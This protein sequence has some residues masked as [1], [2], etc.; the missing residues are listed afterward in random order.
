VTISSRTEKAPVRERAANMLL[1]TRRVSPGAYRDALRSVARTL[2]QL[3]KMGVRAN[4]EVLDVTAGSRSRRKS[5]RMSFNWR[6]MEGRYIG[7]SSSNPRFCH[8]VASIGSGGEAVNAIA[9]GGN[10]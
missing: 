2:L 6:I 1:R 5:A 4:V 7:T 8:C 9:E 3:H 10:A